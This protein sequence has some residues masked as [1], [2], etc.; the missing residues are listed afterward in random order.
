[1]GPHEELVEPVI[2]VFII[3]GANCGSQWKR[4]LL[5]LLLL[6]LLRCRRHRLLLLGGAQQA[7]AGATTDLLDVFLWTPRE[8]ILIVHTIQ[9]DLFVKIFKNKHALLTFAY[10][11]NKLDF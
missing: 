5:L 9:L 6:L 4:R 7:V 3:S 1:M 2:A 11:L 8:K 10:F